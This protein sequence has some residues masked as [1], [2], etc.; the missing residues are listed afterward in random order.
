MGGLPAGPVAQDQHVI[1]PWDKRGDA[2]LMIASGTGLSTVN[3][4]RRVLEDI[5]KEDF[6]SMGCAGRWIAAIN[7]TLIAARVYTNAAAC[8]QMTAV[9]AGSTT[10]G[11]AC[12]G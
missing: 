1:A 7:H 6:T 2:L 12:H 5:G 3:G 9:T 10:Y 8:R 11:D 4:L